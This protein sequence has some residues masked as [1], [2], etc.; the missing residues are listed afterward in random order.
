MD[1]RYHVIF[2]IDIDIGDPCFFNQICTL[3]I[4]D[5]YDAKKKMNDSRK[6]H[7]DTQEY[8]TVLR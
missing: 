1:L 6:C 2:L 3:R 4:L 7:L 5:C 8:Q